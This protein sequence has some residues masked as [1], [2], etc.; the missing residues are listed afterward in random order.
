MVTLYGLW[1]PKF[2]F[3]CKIIF[4][5]NSIEWI[6]SRRFVRDFP[7]DGDVLAVLL[8]VVEQLPPLARSLTPT[9]GP[10][11]VTATPTR[12]TLEVKVGVN[13]DG[14][15]RTEKRSWRDAK[16]AYLREN[17][18]DA[19]RRGRGRPRKGPHKEQAG[20]SNP[21]EADT[22]V[23]VENSLADN[24]NNN[25]DANTSPDESRNLAAVI[26]KIDMSVPPPGWRAGNSNDEI[27]QDADPVP[28]TWS[29]S[30]QELAV[31]NSSIN[32]PYVA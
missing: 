20:T 22:S 17:V 12:S 13:K 29:A 15:A 14:S 21:E 5:S 31:I 30:V 28:R 7:P 16:P 18:P 23:P 1:K 3:W 10:Y 11:R 25:N 27:R 2:W 26:A 6:P 24:V 4:C 9:R 8:V 19:V 32:S